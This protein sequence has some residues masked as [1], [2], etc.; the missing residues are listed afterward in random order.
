MPTETNIGKTFQRR[1]DAYNRHAN[2][3]EFARTKKIK[4]TVSSRNEPDWLICIAGR[5][6]F[7]EVKQ[8]G[9]EQTAPQR[10]RMHWWVQSG[11]RCVVCNDSESMMLVVME[12]LHKAQHLA[13]I[14]TIYLT[15]GRY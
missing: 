4:G 5:T 1:I 7:I 15:D 12:E 11:A 3:F 13:E 6:I 14:E 10:L 9:E 8:L 2:E